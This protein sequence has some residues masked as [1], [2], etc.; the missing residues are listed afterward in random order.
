MR[1]RPVHVS[2]QIQSEANGFGAAKFQGSC[3]P[4]EGQTSQGVCQGGDYIRKSISYSCFLYFFCDPLKIKPGA[5]FK[6]TS[7]LPLIDITIYILKEKLR[8]SIRGRVGEVWGSIGGDYRRTRI[9]SLEVKPLIFQGKVQGKGRWNLGGADFARL[10]SRSAW[11]PAF[12]LL[13]KYILLIIFKQLLNR[14]KYLIDKTLSSY[15][16]TCLCW[17]ES[18]EVWKKLRKSEINRSKNRAYPLKYVEINKGNDILQRVKGL[19][20]PTDNQRV[21]GIGHP[22][23]KN[24]QGKMSTPY[25]TTRYKMAHTPGRSDKTLK[26]IVLNFKNVQSY[27]LSLFLS[28]FKVGGLGGAQN[29]CSR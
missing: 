21:E 28:V 29:S 4:F 25:P 1:K 15:P 17:L 2:L 9:T 13:E 3:L 27:I 23:I 11:I 5:I 8:G 24:S 6:N 18:S 14:F 20:Q 22:P 12:F 10:N 16:V 7:L 26:D 19:N